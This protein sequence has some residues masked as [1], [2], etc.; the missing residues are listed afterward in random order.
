MTKQQ[1]TVNTLIRGICIGKMLSNVSQCS[2][3]KKRVHHCMKQYICIR[4]TVQTFFIGYRY[5]TEDQLSALYQPVYIIAMTNS[6]DISL[7][8]RIASARR[9]S[10]G[11][12]IFRFSSDPFERYTLMPIASTAEQSSVMGVFSCNA[13]CRAPCSKS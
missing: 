12:V 5:T 11:V 6:H 3:A 1:H 10:N 2:R 9:I 4:M 7:P 8:F 13:F